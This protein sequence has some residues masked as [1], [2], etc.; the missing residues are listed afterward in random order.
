MNHGKYQRHG[1]LKY[2]HAHPIRVW[3]Q[4]LQH[5][6]GKIVTSPIN[7]VITPPEVL[8]PGGTDISK[9]TVIGEIPY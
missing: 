9:Y 7:D 5:N 4:F 6:L 2:S 8:L 1:D 3:P